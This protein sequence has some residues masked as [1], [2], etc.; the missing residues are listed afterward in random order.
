MVF[1]SPEEA[2]WDAIIRYLLL[3]M[4]EFMIVASCFI[5]ERQLRIELI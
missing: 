5:A 3:L 1:W 4:K 2:S